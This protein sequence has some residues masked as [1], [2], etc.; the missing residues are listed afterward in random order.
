MLEPNQ[1]KPP[2]YHHQ[3]NIY[4]Y[5]FRLSI[6]QE[7]LVIAMPWHGIKER[8]KCCC[9]KRN[10]VAHGNVGG[11]KGEGNTCLVVTL[12]W[13]QD[14]RCFFWNGMAILSEVQHTGS[15]F[16]YTVCIFLLVVDRLVFP[17]VATY[18][19]VR[20]MIHCDGK[21]IIWIFSLKTFPNKIWS[22]H[23]GMRI[24]VT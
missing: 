8:G 6:E 14:E 12:C 16:S 9:V 13:M 7:K 5:F 15:H 17:P 11:E 24:K 19:L 18:Q 4:I 23:N 10:K 21:I 2:P 1:T 3:N 20:N 22:T